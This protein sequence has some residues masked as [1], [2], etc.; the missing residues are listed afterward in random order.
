MYSPSRQIIHRLQDIHPREIRPQPIQQAH[1]VPSAGTHVVPPLQHQRR[2]RDVPVVHGPGRQQRHQL[3]RG[4]RRRPHRVAPLRDAAL[5]ELPIGRRRRRGRD[6]KVGVRLGVH[7]ARRQVAGGE[8]P[9]A[10]RVAAARDAEADAGEEGREVGEGA[11][12]AREDERV[13]GRGARAGGEDGGGLRGE[14]GAVAVAYEGHAGGVEGG[15]GVRDEG[16]EDGDLDGELG[17]VEGVDSVWSLVSTV[18]IIDL[19]LSFAI[20]KAERER[21]REM[22]VPDLDEEPTPMRS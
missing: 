4:E 2:R 9:P 11:A 15:P 12:E 5:E 3:P 1:T 20:S 6:C 16:G 14:V 18:Y 19:D 13:D 7:V 8:V 17:V 21:E 10:C 22:I